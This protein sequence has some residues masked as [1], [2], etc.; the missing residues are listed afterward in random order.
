MSGLTS[1]GSI[2]LGLR[3]VGCS[4]RGC[5]SPGSWQRDPADVP[6]LG[7]LCPGCAPQRCR[8]PV[9]VSLLFW[10]VGMARLPV[11]WEWLWGGCA[12]L[13]DWRGAS[14]GAREVSL[15]QR[16]W[17]D[18]SEGQEKPIRTH[19]SFSRSDIQ[20]PC[21][22]WMAAHPDPTRRWGVLAFLTVQWDQLGGGRWL[23]RNAA[24]CP[25]PQ[26]AR[27]SVGAESRLGPRT[28]PGTKA[29]AC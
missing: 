1:Q 16:R 22:S 10:T 13:W 2:K 3:S 27:L 28:L 24:G 19:N 5:S 20:M 18:S 9:L 7:G 11:C 23:R 14:E 29:L 26:L 21:P 12:A 4:C 6:S 15:Q 17:C 8:D 25:T